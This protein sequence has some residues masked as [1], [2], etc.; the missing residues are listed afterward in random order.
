MLIVYS[1]YVIEYMANRMIYEYKVN[2][3]NNSIR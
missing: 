1:V 3:T 2:G